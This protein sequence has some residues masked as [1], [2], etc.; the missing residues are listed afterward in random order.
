MWTWQD[1]P[2]RF[3]AGHKLLILSLF[4]KKPLNSGFLVDMT[5]FEPVTSPMW[6]VRSNQLSY[7]SNFKLPSEWCAP[8][9]TEELQSFGRVTN[10]AT[11]PFVNCF[12]ND[13]I[14]TLIGFRFFTSCLPEPCEHKGAGATYPFVNY[15]KL[16]VWHNEH[17]AQYH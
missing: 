12:V 9:P 8:R 11:H 16:E 6:T 13:F 2:I 10:W 17:L 5:G 7:I 14:N 1:L 3:A 15:S 4:F